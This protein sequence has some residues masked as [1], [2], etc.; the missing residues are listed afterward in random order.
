MYIQRNKF[1]AP[2]GKEYTTVLLCKKY[3]EGKKVKTLKSA[4]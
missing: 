4:A 3:R 1:K 2:S